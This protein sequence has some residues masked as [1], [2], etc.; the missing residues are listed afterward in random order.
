VGRPNTDAW[1]I[2][3]G[4]WDILGRWHP[5]TP[6]A[7]AALIVAMGGDP[8]RP[9]PDA[10]ASGNTRVRVLRAGETPPLHE[11]SE[12]ALE[13]GTVLRVG[14]NLPPDL[15][16]GYHELRPLGRGDPTFLIVTPGR[17]FLP[18]QARAW[19]WAAQLYAARSRASWGIGDLADLRALAAWSAGELGAGMV[20]LNPLVAS[21]PLATQ[22]TSPYY[23]STRLYRNPLYLRI[24]EV[25]GAAEA[26]AD[27]EALAARGRALSA[28]RRI[29]RAKV[30]ALKMD[31]L[32]RLFA[33]FAG[34]PGFDRYVA[35]QGDDLNRFATFCAL[36]EVHRAGRRDWPAGHR[37][38]DSP[39]VAR[40]AK[41]RAG[42]VRF[43]AWLQWLLDGQLARAS[44]GVRVIHDL[45]VGFDPGGADAWA[46]Q[47]VLADGASVG[48]PPDDFNENGQ[49]WGVPPFAPEKLRAARYAPLIRT[50]RATLRHAGG[51][52]I[53]HVM[54]LFRLFWVPAGMGAGCGAYVRYRPEETLA[55]VDIESHRAGAIIVGEDLGTVEDGVR[56]TLAAHSILSYRVLYFQPEPPRDYPPLALAS[57]STHDLPTVAGLWTGADLADQRS[58][59]LSPNEAAADG[60]KRHVGGIAG[61]AGDASEED[62]IVAA[63]EALAKSPS[64]FLAA[65]LDDA[66]ACRERPNVPGTVSSQRAN[67]SL[68]LPVPIEDLAAA[69]L[70]RRLAAVLSRKE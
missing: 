40:F 12:V 3:E 51:A 15:P 49:D 46:W 22:E 29:D 59:G 1:G 23:P 7:R 20:L 60:I 58:C 44:R 9:G 26:G 32:E 68:A 53:D 65:T 13:D 4:Y 50:L 27:L 66:A 28:D 25:P 5:L 62:A 31:A 35:E 63:H 54:G 43:H 70:P 39:G 36:A 10:G 48:A 61:I 34:D 38:P 19:G 21:L 55:V 18:A 47:D 37:R 33:W 30:F 41:E 6:E 8:E 14:M 2:D 45:P 64:A 11:P 56:E 42:R 52:R 24:E 17:A 57:V 69:P 16:I 67:W